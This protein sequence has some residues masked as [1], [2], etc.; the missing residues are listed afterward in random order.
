MCDLQASL[1]ILISPVSQPH[2]PVVMGSIPGS[3]DSLSCQTRPKSHRSREEGV[4]KLSDSVAFRDFPFLRL[5]LEFPAL[6]QANCGQLL[7]GYQ[8]EQ[9]Q[10]TMAGFTDRQDSKCHCEF[11]D[12]VRFTLQFLA[13]FLYNIFISRVLC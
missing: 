10:R 4:I 11:Q 7:L 1:Q 2:C 6:E 13:K 8:T 3:Q 12:R 9:N 5:F